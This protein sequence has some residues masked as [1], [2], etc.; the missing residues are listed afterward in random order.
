MRLSLIAAVAD[1]GVIGQGNDIPWRLPRDWKRFKRITMGHHLLMGRKTYES[2]GRPLPGRTTIVVTRGNPKL[3][4]EVVVAR[5]F[6]EAIE[7]ARSAGDD[8][9]F[10]AG[11]AEIYEQGL[12]LAERLYMTWVHAKPEGD[13]RFPDWQRSDWATLDVEFHEADERHP[14]PYT[15]ETLERAHR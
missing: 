4:D 7:R 15:F 10:V 13:T 12:Q 1:N 6:E 3:P 14:W 2:I 9:V 11:G 5:S 8:E